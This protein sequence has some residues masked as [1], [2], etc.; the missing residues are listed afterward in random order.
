MWRTDTSL[1]IFNVDA[2]LLELIQK[3][4]YSLIIWFISFR[5]RPCTKKGTDLWVS[6]TRHAI[7]LMPGWRQ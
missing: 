7:G 5:I 6:G 2:G 3:A 4:Q 1:E